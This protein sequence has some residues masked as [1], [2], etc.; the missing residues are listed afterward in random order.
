M[1][2]LLLYGL[3]YLVPCPATSAPVRDRLDVAGHGTR[4]SNPY[5]SKYCISST[6]SARSV[7]SGCGRIVGPLGARCR[8]SALGPAG[9]MPTA[10]AL[11]ARR[12]SPPFPVYL[13]R[14]RPPAVAP[15][16]RERWH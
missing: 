11:A 3:L 7:R 4:Y 10:Q 15:V 14:R 5:S 13:L 2:Y 12:P 9:A 16:A 1:Q 8:T 6:S